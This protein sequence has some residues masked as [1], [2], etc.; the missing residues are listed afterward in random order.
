VAATVVG[1]P[2]ACVVVVLRLLLAPAGWRPLLPP[3][4][5]HAPSTSAASSITGQRARSEV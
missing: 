5:P 3:S 2:A 1:T 4:S